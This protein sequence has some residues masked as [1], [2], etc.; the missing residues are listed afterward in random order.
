M[1]TLGKI[2]EYSYG[3]Y[4]D[5]NYFVAKVKSVYREGRG[6][7]LQLREAKYFKKLDDACCRAVELASMDKCD[8]SLASFAKCVC[9]AKNEICEKLAAMSQI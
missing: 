4:D 3:I 1:K 6:E 7:E 8:P 9:E 5:K 2:G